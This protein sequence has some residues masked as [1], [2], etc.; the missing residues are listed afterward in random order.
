[1]GD[2]FGS[3][4][5]HFDELMSY[6]LGPSVIL[7]VLAISLYFFSLKYIE[8]WQKGND[9]KEFVLIAWIV[10]SICVIFVGLRYVGELQ[11]GVR[12]VVSCVVVMLCGAFG[13]IKAFPCLHA[14]GSR[15]YWFETTLRM[16][17]KPTNTLCWLCRDSEKLH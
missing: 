15:T 12:V 16:L 8:I 3:I 4:L 10:V 13:V 14:D 6:P 2:I 5:K 9:P 11:S 17:G 7:S 1:M